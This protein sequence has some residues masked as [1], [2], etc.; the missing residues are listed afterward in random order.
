MMRCIVVLWIFS[1]TALGGWI[2]WMYL[3]TEPPYVYDAARSR[4]IPEV[5]KPESQIVAD[6]KLAKVNRICPG[7]SH[8]RFRNKATGEVV[9]TDATAL[10][11]ST[12]VGDKALGRAIWLPPGLHDEVGY[13]TSVCFQC[14]ALQTVFPNLF[15]VVTPELTFRVAQ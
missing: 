3:D 14:N 6:W 12:R 8:R 13:S 4:I 7:S 15:C 11:T 9:T 1:A 10:A 2:G 5:A